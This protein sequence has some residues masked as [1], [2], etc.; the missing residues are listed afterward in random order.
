MPDAYA[1]VCFGADVRTLAA[2]AGPGVIS[3]MPPQLLNVSRIDH[4]FTS[5]MIDGSRLKLLRIL[6]SQMQCETL[7]NPT[8]YQ[9]MR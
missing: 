2:G 6:R 9:L 1:C 7:L 4:G 5:V 3:I 8:G